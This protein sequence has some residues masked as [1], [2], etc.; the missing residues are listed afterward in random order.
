MLAFDRDISDQKKLED[1]ATRF[2]AM[3]D[4]AGDAIFVVDIETSKILDFNQASC[5]SLG[6]TR[7]ELLEKRVLDIESGSFDGNVERWEAFTEQLRRQSG[8]MIKRT[9]HCHKDGS[10]FPVE[11]ALS[12]LSSCSLSISSCKSE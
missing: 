5:S 12:S 11:V 7:E 9:N 10:V 3:L 1:D 4:H 2:R 8:T 6:Y